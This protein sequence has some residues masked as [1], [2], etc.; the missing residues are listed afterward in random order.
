MLDDTAN[1]KTRNQSK[2]CGKESKQVNK[3][4]TK[5]SSRSFPFSKQMDVVVKSLLAALGFTES[6]GRTSSA[7]NY[8]HA[9]YI[10]RESGEGARKGYPE[11]KSRT[12]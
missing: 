11:S 12:F 10:L 8:C 5:E 2:I 9:D 1:M 4:N 6:R 3:R 7:R